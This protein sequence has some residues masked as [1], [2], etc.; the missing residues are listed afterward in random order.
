MDAVWTEGTIPAAVAAGW[1]FA[2]SGGP[3]F[4]SIQPA[5]R[6][7]IRV[8]RA[9]IRIVR[10]FMRSPADTSDSA[11]KNILIGSPG[12]GKS[13]ERKISGKKTNPAHEVMGSRITVDNR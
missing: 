4:V 8:M 1:A 6:A 11:L 7:R 3:V 2:G 9:R 13:S 12:P 10:I 5:A